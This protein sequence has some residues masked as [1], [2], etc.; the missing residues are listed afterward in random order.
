MKDE[1]GKRGG[2]AVSGCYVAGRTNTSASLAEKFTFPS[3]LKLVA[4]KRRRIFS[5]SALIAEIVAAEAVHKG[6]F[7]SHSILARLIFKVA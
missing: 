3:G 6:D 5:I 2:G 1:S 7:K 4:Q